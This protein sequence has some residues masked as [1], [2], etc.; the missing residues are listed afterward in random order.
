MKDRGRMHTRE[1]LLQRICEEEFKSRKKESKRDGAERRAMIEL[2][3][4]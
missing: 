4:L 1:L 2:E 3:A